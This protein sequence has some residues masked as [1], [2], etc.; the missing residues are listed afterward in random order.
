VCLLLV[1][2]RG[3]LTESVTLKEVIFAFQGITGNIVHYDAGKEAFVI[4][5]TV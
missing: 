4:D 5:P 2:G 3:E 1:G